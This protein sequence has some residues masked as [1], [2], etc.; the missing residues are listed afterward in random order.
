MERRGVVRSWNDDKGFGF[1]TPEQGGAEVFA[2]ISTMRGERRPQIGDEVMY[3]LGKD[4]Q[5]RPRA[6]HIRLADVLSLD[7]PSIRRKPPVAKPVKQARRSK[8]SDRS[9]NGSV[10]ALPTK[11]LILLALCVVPVIGAFQL[12]AQTGVIWALV[13]YPVM[14]VVSFVQYWHDK[15]SAQQGRWRTPENTL[16]VVEL[17]GGWPGALVAQQIFRHKT[18]KASFQLVCWLIVI[19]HQVVWAD[20]LFLDGRLFGELLHY[21]LR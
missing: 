19:A 1:I 17:A 2:H 13:A 5:G 11:L 6:E 20:W 12:L 14:S 15:N 10:Q 16:H 7:R 9:T 21:V 3:V 4:A 8:Q 18:R